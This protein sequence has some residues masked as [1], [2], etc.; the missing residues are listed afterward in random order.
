MRDHHRC[1]TLNA[2]PNP[3]PFIADDAI[4]FVVKMAGEFGTTT[5]EESGRINP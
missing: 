4:V 3:A 5:F 1:N 2:Y